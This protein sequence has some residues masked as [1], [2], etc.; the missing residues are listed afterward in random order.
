MIIP[1]STTSI[2]QTMGTAVRT[3]QDHP[4]GTD[5][6]RIRNPEEA[7][8]TFEKVLIEQ[9]VG[10]MTKQLFESNLSGEDGP[11]WM[12]ANG[13]QQRDI[14]TD[15]LTEHLVEQGT[16]NLSSLLHEHWQRKGMMPQ[17]TP[18]TQGNDNG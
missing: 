18:D 9:F 15:V 5:I 13:D 12:K 16:F 11:G 3:R 17:A 10:V 14:L 2:P 8:K 6:S 1:E 4:L 7:A